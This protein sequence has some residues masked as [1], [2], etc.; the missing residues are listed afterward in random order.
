MS[1]GGTPSAGRGRLVRREA[2]EIALYTFTYAP[3]V[4]SVLAFLPRG[5]G[6]GARLVLYLER[7]A[8]AAQLARPLRKTLPRATPPLPDES[9]LAEALTIDRLTL[10]NIYAYEIAGLQAGGAAI[11]F[12]PLP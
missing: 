12:D 1:V 6:P 4:D 5:P 9:D 11:V 8:L 7:S 10:R 2:L 3:S